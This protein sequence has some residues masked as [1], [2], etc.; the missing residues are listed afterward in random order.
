[1]FDEISS[2]ELS[3]VAGGRK[4]AAPTHQNAFMEWIDGIYQSIV[5]HFGGHIAGTKVAQTMYG[6]HASAHDVSRSQAAMTKYLKDGHKLP[7]GVPN[8]FG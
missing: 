2:T 4:A 1:M 3:D 7:K 5:S 6:K 8:M